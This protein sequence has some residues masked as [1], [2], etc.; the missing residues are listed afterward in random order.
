MATAEEAE[1]GSPGRRQARRVMV[2]GSGTHFLSG[3]SAYTIRLAN[4]LAERHQVSVLFMRRLVPA[5]LYPGWKRVGTDLTR[6]RPAPGVASFDGVDWFWLPS[7]LRAALFMLRRRPEVVIFQW[8]TGA[9]LH[10]YLALALLARL[11]GGRVVVEFHEAQDVGEAGIPLVARYVRLVG[12]LFMGLADAFTVHS[13]FDRRLVAQAWPATRRRPTTVLPHGPYDNYAAGGRE[14][15]REAPDG[16]VNLLFFGVIRPFKGLEHLVAAFDALTDE[17][18]ARYWLTVVGETWEGWTLP[19]ERIAASPRRARITFVNRYV[20]DD[21]L[22]GYLAGADAV[23]LPYLRS[24]LSG[25]L[26][27]AMTYGLPVVLSEVGGNIEAAEGYGGLVLVPPGDPTALTD[28][29]RRVAELAGTRHEH[30][31]SWANTVDAYE[32]VLAARMSPEGGPAS[33]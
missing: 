20:T 3:I 19:A 7:M 11:R 33:D 10:S 21:E 5:R 26:Q 16:V 6:L 22:H 31:H 13:E 24:S 17:E 8:W 1:P 27:V 2:V 12:P 18:A 4:A 25:P 15:L 32:P 28:G 23:V 29:L 9:V 14:V 30:P